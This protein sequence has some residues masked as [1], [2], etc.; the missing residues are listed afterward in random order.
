MSYSVVAYVNAIVVMS[1]VGVAQG[2][3]PLISYYR[4]KRGVAV[5]ADQYLKRIRQDKKH[6]KRRKGPY[7]LFRIRKKA[8]GRSQEAAELLQP[9]K[10]RPW[11]Y[12]RV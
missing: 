6:C 10:R 7:V 4:R 1:M 9:D 12:T 8:L 11:Y 2:S 3:Q 5:R